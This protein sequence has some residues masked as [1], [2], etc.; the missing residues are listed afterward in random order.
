MY[1]NKPELWY[2]I[3]SCLSLLTKIFS[4]FCKQWYVLSFC[5]LFNKPKFY[6]KHYIIKHSLYI[7]CSPVKFSLHLSII[8]SRKF[9]LCQNILYILFLH[10]LSFQ[11]I[12]FTNKFSLCRNILS[13]P[14]VSFHL[15]NHSFYTKSLLESFHYIETFLLLYFFT[16]KVFGFL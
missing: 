4:Y 13:I 2:L 7:D 16:N 14:P 10:Q 3:F 11:Y 12:K 15:S 8:Y 9:S 6:S 1:I 5:I